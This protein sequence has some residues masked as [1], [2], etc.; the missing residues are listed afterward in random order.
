MAFMRSGSSLVMG[1]VRSAFGTVRRLS[2]LT[3][4][5]TGIPSAGPSWTSV[6]IP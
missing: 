4:H 5:S 2:R 6:S 1:S 3:A